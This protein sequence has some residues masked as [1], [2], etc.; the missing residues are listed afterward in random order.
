MSRY[1]LITPAHNE[2]Q[3][4]QQAIESVIAQTVRPLKWIVVNDCS[5]DRTPEIVAGYAQR[6][7][8]I[9]LM[10]LERPAGRNFGNKARAFNLGL[11]QLGD[12]D[13]EYIGN[14]DADNSLKSDY[15]AAIL[16]QF[17]KDPKL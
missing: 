12:V 1:V 8:F 11:A 3:F 2:E 10:S 13:Y 4:I 5:S 14:L 15:Y 7:P 9:R 16:Q 17:E 6:Y